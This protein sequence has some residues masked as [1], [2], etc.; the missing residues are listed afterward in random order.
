MECPMDR[1][2]CPGCVAVTWGIRG[3]FAVRLT[4]IEVPMEP[5]QTGPDSHVERAGAVRDAISW[6]ESEG[7][8][9]QVS[10]VKP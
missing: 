10:E 7:L 2:K 6:A 3:W 1:K 5:Y 4:C 8:G 9:C